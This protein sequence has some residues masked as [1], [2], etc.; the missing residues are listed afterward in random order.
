MSGMTYDFASI[1]KT[2]QNDV[3]TALNSFFSAREPI[4]LDSMRYSIVA[5]GKRIRPVLSLASCDLCG[6]PYQKAMLFA[7]ALEIIHTYSLIYDDL[8]CMDNDMLRRG[9]L[10]NHT[11]FGEDI[12]LLA[13]MGLYAKSF[14]ILH[15][16]YRRVG[17]TDAQLLAGEE[18]LLRASGCSGIVMGQY[19]DIENVSENPEV[20]ESYIRRVH[21]LKTSAMLEASVLTGAICADATE[22]QKSALLTYAK[23]IGLAFQIRDDILD[24][25]GTTEQMGKTLGK[26]KKDKKVTFVDIFGVDSAQK[27]LLRLTEEGKAALR[28]FGGKETFL[29][30]LA[31]YLCVRTN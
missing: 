16:G 22:Q 11:V 4:L 17:L 20:D 23:T 10:T 3:N 5:G 30:D 6:A 18:V 26:D 12:A 27:E 15:E 31:D 19:L 7:C 13:G 14:E 25:V 28:I 29:C 8:P 1:L 24:V 21:A 2:Y 9:M